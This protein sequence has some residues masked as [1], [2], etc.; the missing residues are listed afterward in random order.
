[1]QCCSHHYHTRWVCD[2]QKSVVCAIGIVMAG[3]GFRSRST[4]MKPQKAGFPKLRRR[5][6]STSPSLA[7]LHILS[8]CHQVVSVF[9]FSLGFSRLFMFSL[10]C[11]AS[12]FRFLIFVF[13]SI[14]F[15]LSSLRVHFRTVSSFLP[16]NCVISAPGMLFVAIS[17]FDSSGSFANWATRT[18]SLPL[19]AGFLLWGRGS[20]AYLLAMG[21]YC[22]GNVSI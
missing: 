8:Q 1:M 13:H 7:H 17:W 10:S 9:G 12:N 5:H 4:N 19:V 16:I 18:L 22:H 15:V 14:S 20:D 6:G 11:L 3:T 21:M 2:S